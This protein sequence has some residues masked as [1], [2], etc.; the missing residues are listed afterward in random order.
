MS[1]LDADAVGVATADDPVP[2]G[3]L[4]PGNGQPLLAEA[5]VALHQRAAQR[6]ELGDVA[7]AQCDH[8]A[9]RKIVARRS[10]PV[11]EQTRARL[12]G[13]LGDHEPFTPLGEG[14]VVAA[15]AAA[16]RGER[17][18]LEPVALAAVLDQLDRPEALH[19]ACE[20]PPA[21][22]AGAGTGRR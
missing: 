7:P 16:D 3:E 12:D 13:V 4:P 14:E 15:E 6:V 9:A 1:V 8:D 11:G 10:P 5:A 21:P 2:R 17:V 19:D 20:E 22:T 18:A